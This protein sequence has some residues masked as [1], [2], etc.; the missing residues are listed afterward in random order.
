MFRTEN[1]LAKIIKEYNLLS[2]NS[3]RES[4]QP[5]RRSIDYSDLD[6]KISLVNK[7]KIDNASKDR[8]FKE[9]KL[10]LGNQIK[11]E[12]SLYLNTMKGLLDKGRSYIQGKQM[13][14]INYM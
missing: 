8:I 3:M 9:F 13:N 14:T 11:Q 2:P 4:G 7:K 10:N 5:I 6:F 12:G 1:F